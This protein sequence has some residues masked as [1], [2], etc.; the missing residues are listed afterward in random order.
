MHVNGLNPCKYV[1]M[2]FDLLHVISYVAYMFI[3][4]EV[5]YYENYDL[6]NITTPVNIQEYKKLL[7]ETGFDVNDSEYLIDGFVN[8]FSLEYQGNDKV[9]IRAPNLKFRVGNEVILWNKV[10][11]EVKLGRYAGPY[12]DIPFEYYIQSPIGLVPKD[13]G[14]ETRLIFHLS[15]PRNKEKT[16]VNSN[17][18][19]EK[20]SVKY[21]DFSE[22]IRLCMSAGKA[23]KIAR[24]DLTA[25][26]RQLGILKK[27]WKFLILMAKSPLDGA[28]Y[29]FVDK[30]LPFGSSISCAI[31]QKFSDS[32]AH[33]VKKLSN[34]KEN[35]NYLDDFLF[36]ALLKWV[37]NEQV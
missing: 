24:S 5:T 19:A 15:Y 18:P 25:A 8:G 14:R 33:I 3:A 12:K 27:H 10:M 16:S 11:K 29:F 26:F 31:F 32:I 36:I 37:C 7:K 17:I 4:E 34:D 6:E 21:P 13:G 9:K 30:C 28:T 23:C 35:V 22:A 2:T 1:M 20:C